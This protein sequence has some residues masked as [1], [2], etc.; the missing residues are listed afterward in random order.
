ME[1][2]KE[3][4]I[5]EAVIHILDNNSDEP[6]LNEY[7]LELNEDTYNFLLKHL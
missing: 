5:M 3:I 1:Y 4:N 6:V 2:I 7:S